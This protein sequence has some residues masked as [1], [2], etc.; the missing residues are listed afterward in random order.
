MYFFGHF[1]VAGN[2]GKKKM[3][4]QKKKNIGAENLFG[5]LPNCIV[6]ENLYCNLGCVVG[7]FVLQWAGIVL[8]YRGLGKGIRSQYTDCIVTRRG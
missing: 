8:Q 1:A 4:N 6:I 5:L 3:K 7:W 2:N